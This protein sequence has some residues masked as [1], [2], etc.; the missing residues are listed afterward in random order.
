MV[1][2]SSRRGSYPAI[3][4]FALIY[5]AVSWY[6]TLPVWVAGLYLVAS[7]ICFTLYLVDKRRSGT[8]QRR[9]PERTLLLWGFVGGWPG[10]IVAQQVFRHKTKKTSF[11]R[12]FW[13]T[14]VLNVLLFIALSSALLEARR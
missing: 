8:R 10:A 7:L 5:L 13:L 4:G 6:W 9:V 1:I 14:V 11:R 3:V 2:A 12:A